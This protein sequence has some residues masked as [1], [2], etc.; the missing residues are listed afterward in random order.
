M[1][2]RVALGAQRSEILQLVLQGA[3][4]RVGAGLSIGVA[5][6]LAVTIL[7]NRVF[8]SLGGGLVP[9]LSIAAG[10]MLA[11]VTLAGLIPARRAA[12]VDPMQ[13]L[14]NE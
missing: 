6:S 9:S 8:V 13:A 11:V 5:L 2:L 4:L 7:L 3:L 10:V 14:R 1:G 12:S